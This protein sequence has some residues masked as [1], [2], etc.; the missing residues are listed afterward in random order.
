M[1]PALTRQVFL[2]TGW[3]PLRHRQPPHRRGV[4]CLSVSVGVLLLIPW[5]SQSRHPQSAHALASV[6][7]VLALVTSTLLLYGR[8]GIMSVQQYAGEEG[9]PV[10]LKFM[11]RVLAR[12]RTKFLGFEDL[13]MK[14]KNL[15]V[16]VNQVVFFSLCER[17]MLA[18]Q[19]TSS[20]Y[21]LMFFNVIAYCVA[22][23]KELIEREDWS[24]YVNIARTSNV[25]HL[26][27][28]ATKIVLEW[29]KAITF[30]ITVVFMLLVFGL[31]K[32]LKNY[33][34]TTAYL[35]V[36][37]LYFLV[38][39]KVFMDIVAS[40]LEN[41]RFDY[42]ESLESFYVP[43]L[44][45]LLQLSLSALLTGLCVFTGNLRLVFLSAFTNI[46]IK[47]R[48][49][50]EGYIKPLRHELEAL[51]LYRV[52]T[53]SELTN[54][55]DVCAICLTP[56]TC[57]RITPCQHFFHADCLRRCLKGSNKCPICQ[58]HFL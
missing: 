32:G 5:A 51:E 44:I 7:V 10:G 47:Y 21:T 9:A 19:R 30:I 6:G 57:A 37:G 43:A 34:P 40:W 2:P 20:L 22:Y 23:V 28:S 53:H 39:E 25:R 8:Q 11:R 33:T 52:A 36:T 4:F 24:M 56:M 31:E 48:E 46:R 14:M 16:L 15:S 3:R 29:T 38:T 27:L 18:N 42:F 12:A 45:L 58:Y 50:Q 17:L 1:P 54:H 13:Y 41:R 35:V 26:A 55:D 49:L